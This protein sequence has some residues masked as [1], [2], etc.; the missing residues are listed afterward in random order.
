MDES[1][2][3]CNR[4][5]MQ[6]NGQI[7]ALGHTLELKTA[8]F[9]GFVLRVQLKKNASSQNVH[10]VKEFI[11]TMFERSE[12]REA[13]GVRTLCF[14]LTVSLICIFENV[15][16]FKTELCYMVHEAKPVWSEVFRKILHIETA[17]RDTVSSISVSE[18]SLD[19]IFFSIGTA[20]KSINAL[21][22]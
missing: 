17:N 19:D 5:A 11:V 16:L 4:V 9:L 8:F 12:L 2:T 6:V 22:T 1:E 18:S 15:L 20:I 7:L 13:F 21:P 3:L 10:Q 14:L